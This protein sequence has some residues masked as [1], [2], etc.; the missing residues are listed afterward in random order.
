MS[1]APDEGKIVTFYS[2]KGGTGRTMALANVAWILAAN[3]K[4]VLVADWDLESPGLHRFYQPFLK[5]VIK[6]APGVIDL[7]R[8]YERAAT[9]AAGSEQLIR[10]RARTERYAFTLEWDFPGEGRLDY[11]TAGRQ[12][13]DYGPT[14][15][16]LNWDKFWDE[17]NGGRFFDVL[18]ENMKT[19]YDYVLIDSRTGLSDIADI[20][21]IHLPDILVDC[22]T[23]STQGI[24]GAAQVARVIHE[25]YAS[26]GIRILPVPMR[27]DQAEKERAD[28]SLAFAMR[29]FAGLPVM[30]APERRDYWAAVEVPYRAFY[31]YEEILAV[32]GDTPGSPTSLLASFE[33]ITGYITNDEVNILPEVPAATRR[34]V[35]AAFTRRIPADQPRIILDYGAEDQM[36]AEWVKAVLEMVDIEVRDRWHEASIG[37]AIEG[38]EPPRVLSVVTASSTARGTQ[39]VDQPAYVVYVTDS[40]P[41]SQWASVPA[42]FVSGL[43]EQ[44]ATDQVLSLF[45]SSLPD[46]LELSQP[47]VERY[48]GREP[49]VLRAPARNT[50][51]TGREEDLRMLRSQL[52]TRGTAVVLPVTIQG[53]GGVGKTQVALE[54]VHRFK[55]DYDVVWWL[56]CG[57]P[58]FIDASLFDLAGAIEEFS[59]PAAPSGASVREVADG[60]LRLLSQRQLIKRWLLVYDNA[61]DIE[62]VTPFLPAGGGHV[63]ITSRN[64]AWS[65]DDL[66][67]PLSIDVFLRPESIAHL[68]QRVE[69]ITVEEAGKV[70]EILGDLPLAVATAGAWLAETGVSVADYLL[71]LERQGPRALS[72]SQLADYPQRVAQTWDLSLKRLEERSPA[73]ARLLELCAFLSPDIS[74]DL[75]YNPTVAEILAPFDP[76]LSE[77]MVIGRITQEINRLALIKLDSSA[78]QIHMHRLVQAVV[79]DRLSD[80]Q[81][82][83]RRE[84]VHQVLAAARPRREVDDPDTWPRYRMIWPH[85]ALSNATISTQ[86]PVRHL[87]IDRVRYLWQRGDLERGRRL[88]ETT[89]QEW[90]RLL[91]EP[92]DGSKAFDALPRQ[93]FHLRFNLANILRDLARFHEAREIDEEVLDGQRELLGPDHPHTLMT[94]GGL[95]ADLKALG[96]YDEGR[97]MDERTYPAWT[98]LF[99]EEHPRT[100]SAAYNLA[101]SYRITGDYARSLALDEMTL[102]RR[103]AALGPQHPRTLDSA[104]AVARDLLEAGRYHDAVNWMHQQRQACLQ[105]LGAEAR[106]TLNAQMILGIALRSA[107]EPTEAEMHFIDSWEGLIRRFGGD[108]SDAL[109]CRLSHAV[110]LIALNQVYEAEAEI[111]AVKDVYDRRLG[112]D[113]PHTLVCQVNLATA[114]RLQTDRTAATT[115]MKAVRAATTGLTQ[116][117]GPDHPYTLSAQ[118]V[119]A[120]VLA[121]NGQ[122]AE[123][124]ALDERTTLKLTEVLGARHPDTLRSQAN[125]LLSMAEFAGQDTEEER[126]VIVSSLEAVLGKNH[127]DITTLRAGRRLL[128]ALDP[129]PF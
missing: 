32:F 43:T 113:H 8:D 94:A 11:L 106:G 68:R 118:M 2:F 92:P 36:W 129:H 44:E 87:L 79:Q 39:Y 62:A 74:L 51:F 10:E 57:Q 117:L 37:W 41:H 82:A 46:T 128:R 84:E 97:A 54:Y 108:S 60:V 24:D 77:P 81:A 95:A 61:E 105:A 34:E 69:S 72:I 98:E 93:L 18:R 13:S 110:N 47:A 30:S 3:G 90:R 121:D 96:E 20:C 5:G 125:L 112:T 73:A 45:S 25:Q 100:L 7:I 26:R 126:K 86:E 38:E 40:R 75:I 53:L 33:R 127:P 114:L 15:S 48:P 35:R 67:R 63:L 21:T 122:L 28:A 104:I 119:L 9:R 23:F 85:L 6:D 52:Q 116:R 109:A 50:R 76:T 12:N 14:L 64:R 115:A 49:E 124:R 16:A 89:E 65:A 70:A 19:N 59:G 107:G 55:N 101:V 4:R 29:R 91:A 31:S 27:V 42:A 120:V 71:Q 111:R 17:L 103:R 1:D 80:E 58:Q 66:A 102:D 22:F 99:G 56:N 88:A 78:R 83:E 123:A